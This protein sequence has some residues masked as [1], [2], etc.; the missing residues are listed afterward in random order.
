ME[1]EG[2]IVADRDG[3]AGPVKTAPNAF[4]QAPCRGP[5]RGRRI[6]VGREPAEPVG[7]AGPLVRITI[8]EMRAPFATNG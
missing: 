1:A 8:G 3:C 4:G 2:G 5:F 7:R 6:I